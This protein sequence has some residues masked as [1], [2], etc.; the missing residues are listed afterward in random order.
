M[1]FRT[2]SVAVAL[3]SLSAGCAVFEPPPPPGPDPTEQKIAELERRLAA[4]ERILA[5]GALIELTEQ[6]DDLQRQ[7]AEIRGRTDTL[8]YDA[9]STSG[10]QRDLYVDLDDRVRAL[11]QNLRT[12]A[13]AVQSTPA[14]DALPVPGGTDRENYEAAFE[15][16][17]QQRYEAAGAAFGQF[18]ASYPNSPLADNAQYWLAEA[19]YVT[20]QYE[21]AL[22]QFQIVLSG[23]PRSRKI[24]DALLKIGFS[25]YELGRWNA[26]R[27]ALEQVR[28]DYSDSTAAR[29]AE[30][31]LTRMTEEGH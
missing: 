11:E 6:V 21:E 19:Y 22:A 29:L 3:L 31:R 8:E 7:A 17:K 18:L 20:D 15:L 27:S 5:S 25:N 30:Q 1:R 12:Q 26:A 13:A 28:D 16:L 4:L 23:Y 10:R 2:V 14:A 9:E 24:P